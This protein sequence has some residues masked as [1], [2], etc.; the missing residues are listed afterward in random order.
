MPGGFLI[1]GVAKILIPVIL[2][3]G[4]FFGLIGTLHNA[5]V[6]SA[7][8]DMAVQELEKTSEITEFTIQQSEWIREQERKLHEEI[9]AMPLV[10]DD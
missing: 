2:G 3:L 6:R 5:G 8:R 1:G 9:D 4:I 10:T 7:Q